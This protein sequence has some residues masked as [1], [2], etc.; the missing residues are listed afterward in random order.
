MKN[1]VAV[2]VSGTAGAALVAIMTKLDARLMWD[3]G[4]DFWGSAVILLFA[5]PAF[6]ICAVRYMRRLKRVAN[7]EET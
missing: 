6:G 4:S 1:T 5:L 7:G 2:G 3:M